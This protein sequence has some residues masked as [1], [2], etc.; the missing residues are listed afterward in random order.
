M[1]WFEAAL[2]AGALVAAVLAFLR[3]T[4]LMDRAQKRRIDLD[5]EK[6]RWSLGMHQ[7]KGARSSQKPR[8]GRRDDEDEDVDPDDEDQDELDDAIELARPYAPLIKGLVESKGLPLDVDALLEHDP[9]EKAKIEMWLEQQ[10]KKQD[11]G[12]APSNGMLRFDSI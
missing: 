4:A 2:Y 3:I 1:E 6:Y 10:L 11:G 5:S 9:R 12:A 8:N 7:K